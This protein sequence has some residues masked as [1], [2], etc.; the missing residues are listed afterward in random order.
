MVSEKHVFQ[1][2]IVPPKYVFR[3]MVS[4]KHVFQGSIVPPKYVFRKALCLKKHIVK[5]TLCAENML[6]GKR[7]PWQCFFWQIGAP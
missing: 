2:S 3:R 6:S 5:E 4:E 1:G 7:C